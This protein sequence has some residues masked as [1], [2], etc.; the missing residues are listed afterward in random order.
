MRTESPASSVVSVG[1][2]AEEEN[3]LIPNGVHKENGFTPT[4][5]VNGAGNDK[6]SFLTYF[7]G[8]ANKNER[9]AL[10]PQEMM[11]NASFTSPLSVTSMMESELERKFEQVKI[12][13]KTEYA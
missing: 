11:N 6:E 8:G 9:P 2:R 10:G 3:H 1:S 7:F 4:P 12:K 13:V 5:S